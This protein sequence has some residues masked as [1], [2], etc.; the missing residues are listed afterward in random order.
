[1]TGAAILS[2]A[3]K[4]VVLARSIDR[5][6]SFANYA[7]TDERFEA[8]G[9]FFGNWAGGF[10]RAGFYGVWTEKPNQSAEPDTKTANETS[11][12]PGTVVKVGIADFTNAE[13]SP[14][15]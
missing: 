2:I 11:D 7:W 1:M 9:V 14:Q 10:W 13:R 8:G 12:A 15:P 5:G 6:R 3:N 4:I